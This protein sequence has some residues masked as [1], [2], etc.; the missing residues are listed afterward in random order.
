[1]TKLEQSFEEVIDVGSL[2]TFHAKRE[3]K[4]SDLLDELKLNGKFFA[5]LVNGK[6]VG[7]ND[8]IE[9]GS[10]IVLLPKIAGG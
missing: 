4:V 7:L 8:I 6:K 5:I 9:E 10:S 3:R 1:M 2:K